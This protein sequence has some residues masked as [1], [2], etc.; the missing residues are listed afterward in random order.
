MFIFAIILL[1]EMID[2]YVFAIGPISWLDKAY[3][4]HFKI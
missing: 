3:G 1:F 4:G 2:F